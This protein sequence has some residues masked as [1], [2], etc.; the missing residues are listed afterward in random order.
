MSS[1]YI[2]LVF[3]TDIRTE[4]V[5]FNKESHFTI[6]VVLTEV[7]LKIQVSW[8]MTPCPWARKLAS[9]AIIVFVCCRSADEQ[10]TGG[11]SAFP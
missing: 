2:L 3:L 7:L 6:F 9:I 5:Y 4:A 8:N 11:L 10:S 1:R